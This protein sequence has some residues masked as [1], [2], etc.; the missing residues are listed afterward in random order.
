MYIQKQREQMDRTSA[1]CQFLVELASACFGGGKSKEE[2]ALDDGAGFD[3]L[4][5]EQIESLRSALG[6]SDFN[7]MYGH[8]L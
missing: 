3:D 1:F 6:E 8:L 2:I 7:K 5:D 4:T